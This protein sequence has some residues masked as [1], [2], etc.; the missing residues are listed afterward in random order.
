MGFSLFECFDND[1]I[2]LFLNLFKFFFFMI[3]MFFCIKLNKLFSENVIQMFKN[4]D[5]PMFR[6]NNL[7]QVKI[8]WLQEKY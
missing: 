7:E 2:L 1:S 3:S 5:N 4:I 6:K 8:Y